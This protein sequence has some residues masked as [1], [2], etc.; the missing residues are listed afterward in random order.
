MIKKES[1]WDSYLPNL[2]KFGDVKEDRK[3]DDEAH[4]CTEFPLTE[5]IASQAR[6]QTDSN[7]SFPR[8]DDGTVDRGHQSD[9]YEGKEVFGPVW[10]VIGLV[11]RP[12]HGES[13]QHCAENYHLKLKRKSRL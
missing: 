6:N 1:L 9:L 8:H 11:F 5:V 2:E 7:V 10:M 4:V 12:D 3:D 13:P